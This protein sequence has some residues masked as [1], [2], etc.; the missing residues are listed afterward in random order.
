MITK[1]NL[2]D[3]EAISVVAS[4]S[5]GV[6]GRLKNDSFCDDRLESKGLKASGC[7]AMGIHTMNIAS[8]SNQ[9]RLLLSAD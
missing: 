1:E 6:Q 5:G 3:N 8:D 2:D 9:S 4:S 7:D